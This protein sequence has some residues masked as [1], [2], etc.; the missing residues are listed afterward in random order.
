MKTPPP[1]SPEA[2]EIGCVFKP[3]RGMEGLYEISDT[4]IVKSLRYRGNKDVCGI[5]RPRWMKGP[6]NSGRYA[7]VRL[8]DK[9]R[10]IDEQRRIH[11][12]VAEAFVSGR[13]EER[14]EVN[15]IDGNTENNAAYNLEWVTRSE[16]QK[17]AVRTGLALAPVSPTPLDSGVK[18][19][20]EHKDG[21]LEYATPMMMS[22]AYNMDA[23][24][25]Y[26]M[27][28]GAP[29]HNTH[30]GWR[31]IPKPSPGSEKAIE[32]SCSCAVL[33]N[34]HGH[35]Y[36]GQQGIYVYS[37][38]CKLHTSR[39]DIDDDWNEPLGAPACQLGEECES[40]Q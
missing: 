15:H 27:I 2:I 37:A 1:G 13:T 32:L 21:R 10:G 35:G 29:S 6:R 14:N 23:S 11:R 3:V 7:S 24:Y 38:A 39:P 18:Y 34:A 19:C 36:M 8:M 9:S 28:Y 26:R 16:N 22:R 25:T 12:M 4:G 5:L 17:H 20:W 40:C 31:L 33:D 30:R